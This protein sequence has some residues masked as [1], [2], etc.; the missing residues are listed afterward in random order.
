M[1]RYIAEFVGTF[2]L[3]F[4]GIGTALYDG[5]TIG[6][7]GIALAFGFTLLALVYAIG[8]VSGCHINPAVTIG[9]CVAKKFE[10]G[11]SPW[12]IVA[13]LLGGTCGWGTLV[14][15]LYLSGKYDSSMAQAVANGYGDNSALGVGIA[16]ALIVEAI[17]TFVLMFTILGAID[18]AEYRGFAGLAIGT[19]LAVANFVAIPVTNASINPARSLGPALYAGTDYL[20]QLWLFFVGP[21]LGAVI[22]AFVWKAVAGN[23][24]AMTVKVNQP[25]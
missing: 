5:K 21:I 4:V 18:F 11:Q 20:S 2:I 14:L 15:V 10:W 1:N 9:L 16:G 8:P 17:A 19:A 23:R 25:G 24:P 7:A 6:H 12:Y 22:A 3:M 13:Q